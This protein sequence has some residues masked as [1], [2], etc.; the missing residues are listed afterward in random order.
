MKTLKTLITAIILTAGSVAAAN[1][2]VGFHVSVNAPGVHV[3]AGNYRPAYRR[4]VVYREVYQPVVY[5]EYRRP[6]VY[7]EVYHP[8]RYR[9]VHRPAYRRQVVYRNYHRPAYRQVVYRDRGNHRGHGR[10]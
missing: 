7:R 10:W 8:V 5:R 6:V 2:Q 4:P 1:A 9:K 3:R